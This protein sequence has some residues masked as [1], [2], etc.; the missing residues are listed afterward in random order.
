MSL[1]ICALASGSKG[2][3]C[4]VS[5]GHTDILV[6]LGISAGRVEKCLNVLGVNADNLNVLVTHSHSDHVN[7]LKVFCK[8][9][10]NVK[11]HCQ[12]ECF[13]GVASA[14]G[15]PVIADPERRFTVGTL[16]VF[17]IPVSHDV[18]CFGY[19]ISDGSKKAAVVTDV[20]ALNTAQL[21]ALSSCNIVMLECN[22]DVN[23]LYANPKYTSAL[24]ARINSK[25]GHLSNSD[26]AAA[27]AFLASNGVKDF[28]LAHLSE[29]NNDPELA[30]DTVNNALYGAGL[31][32]VRVVTASQNA[33]TGLFEIC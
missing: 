32:G 17:A 21:T 15:V 6:D 18:P 10:E 12:K 28:I 30:V 23:K 13:Y 7:G 2:N 3:C 33:M 11:I 9:H 20:G 5:D 8:H 29:E 26:C 24:K 14:S 25:H 4:Y 16:S 31:G 22:H 19:I 1:K 27:C